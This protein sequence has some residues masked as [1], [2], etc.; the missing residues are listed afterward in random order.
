MYRYTLALDTASFLA[1]VERI[2][3]GEILLKILRLCLWDQI[4]YSKSG[5]LC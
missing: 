5:D 4:V 2:K 1:G 3:M